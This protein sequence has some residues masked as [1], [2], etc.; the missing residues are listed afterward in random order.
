M[1]TVSQFYEKSMWCSLNVMLYGC[2]FISIAC[3]L[4]D[5]VNRLCI[6]LHLFYVIFRQHFLSIMISKF[7]LDN[8]IY[9]VLLIRCLIFIE[10]NVC[11][12]FKGKVKL[13][14]IFFQ[15]MKCQNNSNG[16]TILIGQ[17]RLIGRREERM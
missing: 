6:I 15:T 9:Y 16:L 11:I 4:S 2:A 14:L 8:P 3:W 10:L 12:L 1:A 13:L 5:L 17:L 7:Y